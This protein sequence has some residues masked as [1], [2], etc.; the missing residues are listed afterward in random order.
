[1]GQHKTKHSYPICKYIEI[2]TSSIAS[3]NKNIKE[4]GI[5]SIKTFNSSSFTHLNKSIQQNQRD[6]KK[7]LYINL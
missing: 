4:T 2:M 7:I 6:D 5:I 1:M 3:N